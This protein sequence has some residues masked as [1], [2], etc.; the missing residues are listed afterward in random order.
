MLKEQHWPS[1][2]M[3]GT[4]ISLQLNVR[5][6]IMENNQEHMEDLGAMVA[7]TLVMAAQHH[8]IARL[9]EMHQILVED[10]TAD[11]QILALLQGLCP[12]RVMW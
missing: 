9:R 5:P 3:V 2:V 7:H 10:F 6:R 12:R 11:L 1:S 8:L 4:N